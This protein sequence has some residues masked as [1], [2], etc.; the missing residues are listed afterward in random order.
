M[1][2]INSQSSDISQDV[3]DFFFDSAL[4]LTPE[5]FGVLS[6]TI[7]EVMSWTGLFSFREI[8]RRQNSQT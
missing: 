7:E 4:V 8:F 6:F 3:S 5:V 1:Q 2:S